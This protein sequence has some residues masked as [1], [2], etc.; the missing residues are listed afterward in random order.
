[1][2]IFYATLA[3]MFISGERL[4]HAIV[5]WRRPG[6]HRWTNARHAE[7]YA[8]TPVVGATSH[9]RRQGGL[10]MPTWREQVAA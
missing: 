8:P 1:M 5:T 2:D 9:R 6:R 7:I 4:F 10:T 3:L